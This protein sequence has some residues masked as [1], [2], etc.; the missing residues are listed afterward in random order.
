MTLELW[1]RLLPALIYVE[2]R[3][4]PA[5][6]SPD[7]GAVGILQVRRI[8]VEDVNRHYGLALRWP[9][10][11]LPATNPHGAAGAA[12]VSETTAIRYLCLRAGEDASAETW[13]RT[14]K[15]GRRGC[16]LGRGK[17]YWRDVRAAMMNAPLH[18]PTEAERKEVK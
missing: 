11:F 13:A 5:A 15:A 10:D 17:A 9:D 6:V 18:F 12:W 4:N 7:G 1:A 16:R 8:C 14:W 3:G 2:S